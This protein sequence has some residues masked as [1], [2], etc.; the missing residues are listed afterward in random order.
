M[1]SSTFEKAVDHLMLYEVGSAWKLTPAAE[2]GLIDTPQ[3]RKA[4]G[5]TNDPSDHGKETKY[6]ISKS[7][8]PDINVTT[9]TWTNAKD[10][11]NKRYWIPCKC[12]VLPTRIAALAFDSAVNHGV[13]KSAKFVQKAVGAVPDGIIGELTLKRVAAADEIYVCNSICDQRIAVYLAIIDNDATQ[14]KYKNGWLRRVE[15]MRKYV[16]DL[17]TKF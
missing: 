9:L 1:Y 4:C 3:N 12:E 14:E 11:Y 15:E 16:T 17:N 8:N 13:S 6:G 5:Y 7:A 2:A 10:V